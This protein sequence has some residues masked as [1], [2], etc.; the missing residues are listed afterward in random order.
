MD[1]NA[2]QLCLSPFSYVFLT[3]ETIIILDE[4]IW[5]V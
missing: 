2:L 5:C 3:F 1:Q 4:W